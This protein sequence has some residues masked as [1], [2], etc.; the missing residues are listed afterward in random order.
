MLNHCVFFSGN[1]L[2]STTR[3]FVGDER[4]WCGWI[5]VRSSPTLLLPLQQRV[6]DAWQPLAFFSQEQPGAAKI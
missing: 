4:K 2:N 1:G 6:H 3:L 5:W